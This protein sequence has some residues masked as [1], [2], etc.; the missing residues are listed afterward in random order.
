MGS[1]KQGPSAGGQQMDPRI[2]AVLQARGQPIHTGAEGGGIGRVFQETVE[3]GHSDAVF[4]S[5]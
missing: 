2:P 1:R 3:L 4:F 5:V